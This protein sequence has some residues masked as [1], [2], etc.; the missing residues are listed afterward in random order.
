MELSTEKQAFF[1][2]IPF[3]SLIFGFL[4]IFLL[5]IY[6]H[7]GRNASGQALFYPHLRFFWG[8]CRYL[9]IQYLF[10]I[11]YFFH[12]S[13]V[14]SRHCGKLLLYVYAKNGATFQ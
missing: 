8:I 5:S 14:F 13:A 11:S 10:I 1:T 3:K 7:F 9:Y 12:E 6:P 2:L 4:E